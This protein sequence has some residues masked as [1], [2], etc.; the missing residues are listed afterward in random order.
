[1]RNSAEDRHV[2]AAAVAGKAEFVVTENLKDFPREATAPPGV[3][4]IRP[5]DFLMNLMQ[6][7]PD[8]MLEVFQNYVDDRCRA[9]PHMTVWTILATLQRNN[10]PL[11]AESLKR[12]LR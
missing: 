12:R 1:M 9:N 4:A 6:G 10:L 11:L 8:Q 3:E 5:D 7:A 2:L